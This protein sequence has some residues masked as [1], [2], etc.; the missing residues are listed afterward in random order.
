MRYK[1]TDG[2]SMPERFSTNS[3]EAHSN[4]DQV[5]ANH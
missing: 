3:I 4:S 2:L 5:A 1:E